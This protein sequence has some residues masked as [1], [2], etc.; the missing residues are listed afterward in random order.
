[1]WDDLVPFVIYCSLC[2]SVSFCRELVIFLIS[3]R[4]ERVPHSPNLVIGECYDVHLVSVVYILVDKPVVSVC[5][6]LLDQ[7]GEINHAFHIR[8][9]QV[10][11]SRIG[12]PHISIHHNRVPGLCASF[13]KALCLVYLLLKVCKPLGEHVVRTLLDMEFPH[14][15]HH[16]SPLCP[17]CHD[18][19]GHCKL[20]VGNCGIFV[21]REV[22]SPFTLLVA[23]VQAAV[24]CI[25]L[26]EQRCGPVVQLKRVAA[27]ID[28]HRPLVP[29]SELPGSRRVHPL[30]QGLLAAHSPFLHAS[31]HLYPEIKASTL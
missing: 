17:I 21:R 23:H 22:R 31:Q 2:N 12:H 13:G 18:L 3:L 27:A 20:C 1:M 19:R 14:L 7:L 11:H 4:T 28:E 29:F 24:P 9:G 26:G 8:A 5:L 10:N 15:A 6:C 16:C 30:E 25:K